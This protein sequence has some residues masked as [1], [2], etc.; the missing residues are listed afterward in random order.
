[1]SRNDGQPPASQGKKYENQ[2]RDCQSPT[3]APRSLSRCRSLLDVLLPPSCVLC[4]RTVTGIS[5]CEDCRS[6]L[7]WTGG[8]CRQCGLPLPHGADSI[9]GR[10]VR[11]PPPYART[12]SPLE[13]SFPVDRLVQAFKFRR[14]HAAGRVLSRLLCDWLTDLGEALPEAL[15][16]VPLHPLRFHSRGF[17]Q[18]WELARYAGARLGIPVISTALRRRRHTPAQSGLDRKQR[19]K[20]IR[21]VFRWQA[22]TAAPEHVAVVD[23]VMTTGTTAAECARVLRR[24]GARRVDV[25]VAARTP[26]APPVRR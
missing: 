16:P 24:A 8:H 11:K 1:M 4:G 5:L 22:R 25:W 14:Q 21:G 2:R 26:A 3:S 13:Y 23:D 6:D 15:V 7:P 19:H 10:C 17:N 9:C 20:N 12:L 18:A